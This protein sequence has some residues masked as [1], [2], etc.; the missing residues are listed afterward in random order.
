MP[1]LIKNLPLMA[2]IRLLVDEGL[3]INTQQS[4][5]LL[6]LQVGSQEFQEIE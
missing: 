5:I 3:L 2:Q 6:L 1:G 4:V